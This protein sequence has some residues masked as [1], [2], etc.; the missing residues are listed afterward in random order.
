MEIEKQI[1]GFERKLYGQTIKHPPSK[2][3]FIVET[4]NLKRFSPRQFI[5]PYCKI[6]DYITKWGTHNSL[7]RGQVQRFH[8]RLCNKRFSMR[9]GDYRMR[10]DKR[11]IKLAL[12]MRKR[13]FSMRE[14][15]YHLNQFG[16]KVSHITIL[17]WIRKWTKKTK[18]KKT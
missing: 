7:N 13:G 11:V 2:R 16:V 18:A 15:Q 9:G 12:K 4:P 8:C 3:I 1:K 5:C 17:R 14:I 10:H 6:S